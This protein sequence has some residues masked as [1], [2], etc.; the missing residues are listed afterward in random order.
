LSSFPVMV[1][2][3]EGLLHPLQC[4][5]GRILEMEDDPAITTV[6]EETL[7]AEAY[8]VARTGAPVPLQRQRP[9]PLS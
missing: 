9:F 8:E 2:D 6:L 7:T 3:A 1:D 4:D 5:G